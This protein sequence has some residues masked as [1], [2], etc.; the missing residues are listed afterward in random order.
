MGYIGVI[1]HLLTI[2]PNFQRDMQVSGNSLT[3]PLACLED[4]PQ[5]EGITW[6]FFSPSQDAFG[7][8]Q[9]DMNHF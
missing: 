6:V 9:V 5:N 8:H 3:C 1:T 2:D 7:D 4:F